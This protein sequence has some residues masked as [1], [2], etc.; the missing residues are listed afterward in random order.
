MESRTM[1][2]RWRLYTQGERYVRLACI[3]VGLDVVC[4]SVTPSFYVNL[5]LSLSCYEP[6]TNSPP[7]PHTRSRTQMF[8]KAFAGSDASNAFLSY[9]R[10]SFP[11]EKMKAHLATPTPAPAGTGTR[12]RR[13]TASAS[14][15]A[16]TSPASALEKNKDYLEL[17][18]QVEKVLPRSR[19]FAPWHYYLKAAVI[20][21]CAVG[22][23]TYMHWNVDYGWQLSAL[24]GFFMALIGLNVQHDANHGAV[25]KHAW[26]NRLMG[27]SQNWI[28]GS[29]IDWVHQHVVQHHIHCGDVQHDP[30][31]MGGSLLRL[32]PTKPTLAHQAMQY[33]YV[34]VLL[35]GFGFNVVM[36]AI[37]HLVRGK[38]LKQ[39]SSLVSGYRIM[40]GCIWTFFILRWVALPVYQTGGAS[41]LLSIAPMYMVAGYWLSF[42]FIISHNFE[43]VHMFDRDNGKGVNKSFLYQQVTSSS[44]VGGSLLCFLNGGL[45]YQI[46]HHLF[47]RVSHCHYPLISSTVRAYCEKMKIPYVHFGGVMENVSSLVRHLEQLGSGSKLRM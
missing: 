9:H 37:L 14:A 32:N 7:L 25:S 11:H 45:N 27:L 42:F 33:A 1:Q 3:C 4:M 22:L 5:P 15:S 34:F 39:M 28:G 6:D 43:G 29:A 10:K 30:D 18:K 41:V 12:A 13:S 21:S 31:I 35:A 46:E 8:V 40:E 19:A 20:L 26:V 17:C 24:L 23:E 38:H 16:A 44:N 2:P 47:P 36:Q